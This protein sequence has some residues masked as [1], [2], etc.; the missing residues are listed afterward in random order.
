MEQ[1]SPVISG[2]TDEGRTVSRKFS[3]GDFTFLRGAPGLFEGVQHN[4]WYWR[5]T[6]VVH[7][8]L[9]E[10]MQFLTS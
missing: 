9:L 3:M 2:V 1:Q 7:P 8:T 4:L 10:L 5:P 6:L